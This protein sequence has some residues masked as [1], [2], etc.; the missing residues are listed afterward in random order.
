MNTKKILIVE[1]ES[2]TALYIEKILNKLGYQSSGTAAT[3]LEAIKQA[4]S[5]KPDLVLMDINLDG[6]INGIEIVDLIQ[7]KYKIPVV[8][9]TADS[10]SDTIEA[11]I[12]TQPYGFILKPF[13]VQE[14]R[15]VLEMALYKHQMEQQQREYQKWTATILGAIDDGV[16]ATTDDF[17]VG[18]MNPASEKLC[19]RSSANVIGKPLKNIF[20]L[21]DTTTGNPIN[22]P[23]AEV[24]ETGK[25]I[26]IKKA[27]LLKASGNQSTFIEASMGP[28]KSEAGVNNKG[29]ILTF[30]DITA[31]FKTEEKLYHTEKSMKAIIENA[32]EG[33]Y[34]TGPD[35]R[36][37]MANLAMANIFAKQLKTFKLII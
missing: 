28:I 29:V 8:Y 12:N 6:Q 19:G 34:R 36:F 15:I 2:V 7:K 17:Y 1:N 18:Y 9:L 35:G 31:R 23:F 11:A 25:T 24:R 30:R 14:L 27:M 26:F 32:A 21:Y 20:I 16:I 33:I 13:R 3:G 5:L 10:D 4:E 22:L 37:L